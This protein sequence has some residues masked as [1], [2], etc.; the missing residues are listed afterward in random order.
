MTLTL[1]DGIYQHNVQF[2]FLR[3]R[4]CYINPFNPFPFKHFWIT[5]ID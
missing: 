3:I 4:I 5:C 2:E 1:C